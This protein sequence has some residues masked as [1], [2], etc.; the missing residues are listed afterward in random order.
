ADELIITYKQKQLGLEPKISF[1][2][3]PYKNSFN[4]QIFASYFIPFFESSG[5]LVRQYNASGNRKNL[6]S[7]SSRN[8]L[9]HRDEI[10][11]TYNNHAFNSVAFN[12]QHIYIGF[13]IGFTFKG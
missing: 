7:G 13:V 4:V 11:V 1:C 9:T 3:N 12:A 2:S 5:I 6:V 10:D 8:N